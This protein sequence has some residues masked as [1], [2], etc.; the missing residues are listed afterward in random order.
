MTPYFLLLGLPVFFSL[1]KGKKTAEKKASMFP[2]DV[3]FLIFLAILCLRSVQ[4]GI[5]L[6][7]YLH[8]FNQVKGVGFIDLFSRYLEPGY[9]VL[10]KIT[11]FFGGNFQILIALIS[12]LTV[13][14]LWKMYRKESDSAYLTLILFA[15]VAPFTVYFSGLRQILAVTLGIPAYY[16]TKQKKLVQ[17][18]L[19]VALAFVFHQSAL[20]LFALYP[21]YHLKLNKNTFYFAVPALLS[22]VFFGREIFMFVL[23]FLGERYIQRYST[24]TSTGAYTVLI[25]LFIFAIYT[26]ILPNEKELDSDTLGLRNILLLCVA[27]Q[28]FAPVNT[29][30][31]RMNYYFLIFIPILIPRIVNAAKPHYKKLASMSV[32]LIN[33]VFTAWFF[34]NAYCGGDALNVFPYIPFWR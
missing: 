8:F 4:V 26:Y 34:Y 17:F 19:V 5:D 22:I 23:P 15:T 29:I 12:F 28:S 9:F 14:P 31:M 2:L 18:V 27:I 11:Q 33:L 7:N 25:L 20:L 6:K 1:F 30:A 3:F 24:V 16:Y 21:I 10:A 13:V 32:V